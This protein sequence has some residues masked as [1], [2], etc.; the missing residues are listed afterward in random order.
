MQA[1]GY[2]SERPPSPRS[3]SAAQTLSDQNDAFLAYCREHAYEP[4][5]SFLDPT[6]AD[7]RP[8]F[9]QLLRYLERPE[10][11]FLVVV[12][13][14]L[15]HLGETITAAT[16]AYFQVESLG[17]RV[18]SL[19]EGE[20]DSARV[21]RIWSERAPS[22]DGG[23]RVREAMQRRA[24]SGQVLGRP[25]YGYRVGSDRRL[26]VAEEEGALVRYI[27]RLYLHEGMGI[28]RIAKRLNEAGF[29]TRRDRNW[30][31]VTIRDLLRN[32]VYLGTYTRFGVTV[33]DSHPALVNEAEMC[34]VERQMAERR[35]GGGP[36]QVGRFLLAGLAECAACGSRMIGVTRRQRWTRASGVAV[37]RSYR[38][39]QC[40]SR[41]NQSVCSYHSRRAEDLEAEVLGHL[42][43]DA[44]GAVRAAVLSA[45]DAAAVAA[46]TAV[47]RAR[48]QSRLRALDRRLG[49]R[50]GLARD[51]RLS[52]DQLSSAATA[53]AD[54]HR[55]TA[56][57]LR[58]LEERAAAQASDIQRRRRQDEQMA[59]LRTDW[60][61]MGFGERQPLLRD[62]VEK[63][64]VADER[65]TT[66][67]RA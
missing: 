37:E 16:R 63:I 59:R 65:I 31:M 26:G 44:P 22:V 1:I 51:G 64:V 42:T 8:G 40:G 62:I 35:T 10:K 67:L 11:G 23:A 52:G 54:E 53:L 46:E 29:R 50:L 55:Q 56:E 43:G 41:A 30:S 45:G 34:A 25:P 47:E 39:Y 3:E 5:A 4:A 60:E 66:V 49:E 58:R 27:F 13:A 28:R 15:E 61:G 36:R 17:A 14:A 24:V 32:R 6:P 18:A 21:L 12:V 57:A 7:G 2:F 9:Q 38:Y 19:A 20:L 48:M 33:P